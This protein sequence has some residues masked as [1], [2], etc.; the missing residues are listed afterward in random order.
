MAET[1]MFSGTALQN[2]Y[3]NFLASEWD[4]GTNLLADSALSKAFRFRMSAWK[5]KEHNS[6]HGSPKIHDN[7]HTGQTSDTFRHSDTFRN[8]QT[9]AKTKQNKRNKKKKV[10]I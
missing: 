1:G 2:N 10:K 7:K 8:L 5:Q 9:E 6:I 4:Y 3:G